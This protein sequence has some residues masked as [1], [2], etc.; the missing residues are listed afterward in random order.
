MDFNNPLVQQYRQHQQSNTPFQNNPLL[1]NNPAFR[2]GINYNDSEQMK[3]MQML[4]MAHMQKLKEIQQI[5]HMEKMNEIENNW[6]KDKIRESVI[7]PLK[8]EKKNNSEELIKNIK[9]RWGIDVIKK[10]SYRKNNEYDDITKQFKDKVGTQRQELWN[11]RTNVPYKHIIKDEKY[12]KKFVSDPRKKRKEKELLVHKVTNKDKE[13][14]EED[15]DKFNQNIEKHDNELKI[16]YSTSKEVEHKKK[17]EYNHKS[18]Y[19]VKYDPTD[20]SK[21]KKDKIDILK[22]EQ[23]KQEKDKK[24]INDIYHQLAND[25][26]FSNEELEKIDLSKKPTSKSPVVL[27]PSTKQTAKPVETKKVVGD[28][29]RSKRLDIPTKKQPT[30]NRLNITASKKMGTRVSISSGSKAQNRQP[31][32]EDKPKSKKLSFNRTS[33]AKPTPKKDQPQK[34]KINISFGKKR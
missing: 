33:S 31:Q 16:I 18:K 32:T 30:A 4:Q 10:R 29:N 9:D 1:Q 19:R 34:R 21:M 7:N 23:K 24:N 25:G 17:F 14:V 8:I 6:D 5:K 12:Y 22:K 3:Q 26:I 27:V 28:K 15:F 2:N 11:K 13:G 20:H